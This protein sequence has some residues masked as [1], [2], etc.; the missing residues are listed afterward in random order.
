MSEKTLD[1]LITSLKTE[2]ID[3]A[4][5][6]AKKIVD[7]AKA[8]AQKII[9]NAEV[10]KKQLLDNAEKEAEETLNKGV[11]ALKQA[12][13]DINVT[14]QNDLLKLLKTVL[15]DEINKAFT[16]DLIK[17]AVI[18]VIE[19]VN[20]SVELKLPE[21]FEKELAEYVQKHLQTSGN[22][23]TITKDDSIL[24]GFSVTKTDQGWS[25][26]ITP[27]EVAEI[28]NGHLSNRWINVL[29]SK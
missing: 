21:D 29:K 15:Q 11:G 19:N 18:K 4:E 25:Y 27:Q 23:V 24:K 7:A 26:H 17:S 20:S 1:K 12:A 16:P 3:A 6:E 10:Q 13:R 2:A 22:L 5:K 9:S 28:L 14:V 8:Q